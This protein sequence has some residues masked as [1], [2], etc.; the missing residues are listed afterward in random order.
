MTE[1]LSIG[2]YGQNLA[3]LVTFSVF[4]G[5]GWLCKNRMKH[6]KCKVNSRCFEFEAD[7]NDTVHERPNKLP[8]VEGEEV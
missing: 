5:I 6:S 1:H 4:A 2:G 3:A 8:R 7:G